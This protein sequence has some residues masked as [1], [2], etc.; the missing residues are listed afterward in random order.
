MADAARLLPAAHRGSDD[1]DTVRVA[2]L[3]A[4]TGVLG[5]GSRSVVWTQ[6]CALRCAGCLAPESW[7]GDHGELWSVERLAEWLLEVDDTDGLTLSG[8]EPFL[9]ATALCRLVDLLRAHR[10]GLSVMSYSGYRLEVL[11]A[12]GTHAQR[13]LLGRLDILV[14]GPFVAQR[15]APLRWR[16]SANQRIHVLSNRHPGLMDEP[17]VPAGMQVD[18]DDQG[19]L[20][21][22]GVPADGS[23]GA[24]LDEELRGRGL[25][26]ARHIDRDRPMERT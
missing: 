6:A 11:R 3:L 1:R 14:D 25:R 24:P 23:F 18:F 10:P 13:E 17:D 7:N 19:R 8:G 20:A 5:P 15:R 2:R 9:Q 4:R 16:G 21:W 22:T 12:R 26:V